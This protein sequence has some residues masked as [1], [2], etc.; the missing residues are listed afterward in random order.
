MG[1]DGL[2]GAYEG[3][4]EGRVPAGEK[5]K[6]LLCT[7]SASEGLNLQT[8]GVL[9][10]F[11]MPWNPMRV[12]QRIGRIDRIGQRHPKVWIRNYFL[13][14]TIEAS[15]YKALSNRIAW[16]EDVVGALQPILHRVGQAIEKLVTV[17]GQAA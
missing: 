17:R 1:R 11:D 4:D 7:E 12:E 3:V 8:C 10:N 15:V 14:E 2:V 6:I 9:I 16:F 5:V 13:D